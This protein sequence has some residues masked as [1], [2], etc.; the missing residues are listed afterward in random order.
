MGQKKTQATP[1]NIFVSGMLSGAFI[2]YGALL[3]FTVQHGLA[4]ACGW[5]LYVV[6]TMTAMR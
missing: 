1:A 6:F 5:L 2:A 3:C 4:G